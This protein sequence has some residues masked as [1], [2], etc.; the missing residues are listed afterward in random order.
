MARPRTETR[1]V[2]AAVDIAVR[3]D[4]VVRLRDSGLTYRTI[5]ERLGISHGQAAQ[6]YHRYLSV[7]PVRDVESRRAELRRALEGSA[8][9]AVVRAAKARRREDW[10]EESKAEAHFLR[11][12]EQQARLDGL[13]LPV[14]VGV[15]GG[16]AVTVEVLR[17]FLERPVVDQALFDVLDAEVV[18]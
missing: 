18:G 2:S 8:E 9:R 3:V 12:L 1:A 17:G 5:G 14:Q 10:A 15:A 13:N 7:N 11:V 16:V 4:E 6:D